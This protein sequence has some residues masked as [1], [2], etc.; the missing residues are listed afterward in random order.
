MTDQETRNKEMAEFKEHCR[1]ELPLLILQEE[2]FDTSSI[3]TWE[4]SKKYW[5]LREH[6]MIFNDMICERK[7][8]LAEY[9]RECMTLAVECLEQSKTISK[10]IQSRWY[11]YHM[12]MKMDFYGEA[13]CKIGTEFYPKH[14]YLAEGEEKEIWEEIV[15]LG[16]KF[17]QLRPE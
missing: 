9:Y 14:E 15:E 12:C 16:Y 5:R 2:A 8:P 6:I 1:K 4:D 11:E 10:E 7:Y 13:N 3:K 17:S